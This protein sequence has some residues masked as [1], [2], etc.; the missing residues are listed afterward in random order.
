MVTACQI[1]LI[2]PGSF[3][4]NVFFLFFIPHFSNSPWLKYLVSKSLAMFGLLLEAA[5]SHDSVE[6]MHTLK[7]SLHALTKGNSTIVEFGRKFKAICDQNAAIGHPVD[8]D[9]KNYWLL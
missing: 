8:E 2:Q 3:M 7:D 4:I 5:Y 9:D 6:Q 1:P